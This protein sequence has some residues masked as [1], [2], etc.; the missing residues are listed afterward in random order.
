M[1]WLTSQFCRM[2]PAL[3][4]CRRYGWICTKTKKHPFKKDAS[5]LGYSDS[6]QE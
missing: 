1:F 5:L 2:T 4:P 6:N 3:P